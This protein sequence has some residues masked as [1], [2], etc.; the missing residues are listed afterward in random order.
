MPRRYLI[1]PDKFKGSLSAPEAAA[2]ISAGIHRAD[3]SAELDIC[4][5]A[6]G[7]DG[8]METMAAAM[9]GTWLESPA[10]DPLGRP[11]SC[12]YVIV[13][14]PE[15]LAAIMEMAESAGL[16]RISPEERDPLSATTFGTGMQIA[17]A[18]RNH[19]SLRRI[20]LGLGGSATND[21][22]A[23]MAAALGVRFLNE[24]GN[25]LQ[26]CP[27]N[28]SEIRDVDVSGRIPL[29]EITAA[30]DVDNPLLG[31][32]GATAVFS[33][34]KGSTPDTRVILED[35]LGHLVDVSQGNHAAQLP[36]AGA[37]GGLGFGLVH[38]ANAKLVEGF[39]LIAK[40]LD[41]ENRVQAA[42]LVIT[43]E[44]ALDH[45]SL[46]GKGPVAIARLAARHSVRVVGLCGVADQ[47]A[48][49]CGLFEPLL[50]LAD[51]GLP[52]EDLIANAATLL[53][54]IAATI[55]PTTSP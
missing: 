12:R 6:D 20:I 5:I 3:P 46:A 1:A 9:S 33:A 10:V 35:A 36:G 38:F 40:L 39:G 2:A 16:W 32:R 53:A 49:H 34:Q 13:D 28:L 24:A 37:A 27:A 52:L 19:P 31:Q 45:Q 26:P 47:T 14:T 48:R 43:G 41:L 51:T 50:A 54:D 30:C 17:H 18:V 15:G 22:G 44:G 25:P 21:G 8:F 55:P 4:P 7:G 29:P 23:G 11:I 42:D